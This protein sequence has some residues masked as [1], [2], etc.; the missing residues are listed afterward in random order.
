MRGRLEH[1]GVNEIEPVPV[2]EPRPFWSVMIP[3]FN[4]AHYLGRTLESVLEQD[5]GSDHMQIEVID[6]CSDRDQP[7]KVVE[8][9]GRGRVGFFRQTT[10][11]GH[12]AN[13][14]TC[15]R[16]AKGH[17]VHLLHGDDYV[18]SGF[19]S[20]LG[21]PFRQ[22]GSLGA[23][24]CRHIFAD[25]NGHWMQISALER[26]NAGILADAA[27]KLASGQRIQTPSMVVRRAVYEHL[28]GFDPRLTWT[29]D[30]EMWIRIAVNY[31]IWFEPEPLA[32]YRQHNTSSSSDKTLT[33]ENIRDLRR[34]INIFKDHFPVDERRAIE[35]AA[36]Y[37]YAHYAL[38]V[39]AQLVDQGRYDAARIQLYEALKCSRRYSVLSEAIR[40]STSYALRRTYSKL[41]AILLRLF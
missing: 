29:E 35:V 40:I 11:S 1:E 21:A 16:R 22:D 34:C 30:W 5:P 18:R 4:C 8:E 14:L 25:G 2:G 26:E 12:T 32:V 13:F 24:F 33:G 6:D 31:R 37:K 23:A 10:N 36:L 28:G 9:V 3:T 20:R 41:R 39:S 15:L 7:E 17:V 38:S 19:Y 27:R